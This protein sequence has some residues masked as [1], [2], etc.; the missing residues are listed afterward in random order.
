MIYRL[1]LLMLQGASG[2]YVLAGHEACIAEGDLL[3]PYVALIG[4]KLLK[5]W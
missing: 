2:G 5:A 1:V 4:S 3:L